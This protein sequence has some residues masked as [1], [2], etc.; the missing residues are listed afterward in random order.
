MI[1]T[2]NLWFNVLKAF[3]P[4]VIKALFVLS[5]R[6]NV[7]STEISYLFKEKGSK[8]NF[9]TLQYLCKILKLLSNNS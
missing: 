3:I 6:T 8:P 4:I 9:K 7:Y 1:D 2:K 5:F